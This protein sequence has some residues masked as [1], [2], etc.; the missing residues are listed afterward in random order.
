MIQLAAPAFLLMKGKDVTLHKGMAF[1]VFT[2]SDFK[3]SPPAPAP[4]VS[5]APAPAVAAGTA[6]EPRTLARTKRK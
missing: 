4:T 5:A 1:E 2:D 6:M 3:M